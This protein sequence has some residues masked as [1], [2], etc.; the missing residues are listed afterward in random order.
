MAEE[1]SIY[2]RIKATI[3][4]TATESGIINIADD[5][6]AAEIGK[7]GLC[8]II[9][10]TAMDG[11][12]LTIQPVDPDDDTDTKTLTDSLGTALSITIAA[13]RYIVLDPT[14]YC[15]IPVF[16]LVCG[17]AQSGQDAEFELVFRPL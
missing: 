7:L 15:A 13:D 6:N 2:P 1:K 10:P 11:T 16:K 9:T 14:K 8:A 3:L 4:D 17:T 12:T 5:A